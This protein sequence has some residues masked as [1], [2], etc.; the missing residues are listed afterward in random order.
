MIA[1][2]LTAFVIAIILVAIFSVAFNK[3][4]PWGSAWSFFLVLFLGIWAISLWIRPL[5]I[6]AIWGM[7]WLSAMVIG[8]MLALLLVAVIPPESTGTPTAIEGS[9][10][11]EKKAVAVMGVFFWV[12]LFLF[13][14]IIIAG[15]L[16][17]AFPIIV[18]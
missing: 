14:I 3:R 9:L 12:L 6:Y 4:G 7:E 1:P 2:L 13:L 15:N 10:P 8:V 18:E 5:G 16:Q 11:E 17:P